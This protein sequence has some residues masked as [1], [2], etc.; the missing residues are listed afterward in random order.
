MKI[1]KQKQQDGFTLMEVVVTVVIMGIALLPLATL[2]S[3]PLE[4]TSQT[5]EML[6]AS[7]LAQKYIEIIKAEPD[8]R[9]DDKV[10]LEVTT[11]AVK[12]EQEKT[13]PFE[14]LNLSEKCIKGYTVKIEIDEPVKI[15]S[16][17]EDETD[18]EETSHIEIVF[19]EDGR[20]E[21]KRYNNDISQA[22]F[23]N[24]SEMLEIELAYKQE[25]LNA[26][27]TIEYKMK[28]ASNP[29]LASGKLSNVD[30]NQY[31]VLRITNNLDK[32]D[33][34]SPR[35]KVNI[36]N[37][38]LNTIKLELNN[39]TESI[40]VDLEDGM[41]IKQYNPLTNLYNPYLLYKI[42]VSVYKE[43]S[44]KLL[45]EIETTKIP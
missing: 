45:A 3:M 9:L 7:Q 6:V 25:S 31:L 20:H 11:S 19:N 15:S 32:E 17:K 14:S 43:D 29:N 1:K 5:E 12:T 35:V 8:L 37:K 18:G 39:N 33:D 13:N 41:L 27:A 28:N 36:S 4:K 16:D 42:K 38:T 10:S 22:V 26:P 44:T 23:T 30:L 24:T 2:F 34:D 40:E 21:L